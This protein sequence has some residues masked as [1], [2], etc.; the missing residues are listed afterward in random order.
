MIHGAEGRL[1][2]HGGAACESD[3][4]DGE[5]CFHLA[6]LQPDLRSSQNQIPI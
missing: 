5:E 4:G 1:F 2:G 6:S 3:G